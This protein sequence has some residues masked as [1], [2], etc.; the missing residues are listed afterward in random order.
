LGPKTLAQTFSY[1]NVTVFGAGG[2]GGGGGGG[3]CATGIAATPAAILIP[4][5]VAFWR[6]RKTRKA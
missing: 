5:L 1:S 4:M 2:G 6:R 3:G